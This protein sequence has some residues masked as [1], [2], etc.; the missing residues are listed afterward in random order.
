MRTRLFSVVH[1]SLPLWLA[2]Q[3]APL[4]AAELN[5]TVLDLQ[6]RALAGATVAASREPQE[7]DAQGQIVRRVQRSDALGRYRFE[8]LPAGRYQVSASFTGQ[9]A[10]SSAAQA[11]SDDAALGLAPLQLQPAAGT[12]RGT[13]RSSQGP[14]PAQVQMVALRVDG[15]NATFYGE[16]DA[17]AYALSLP[18]G[19]YLYRAVTAGHSSLHRQVILP[20]ALQNQDLVLWPNRGSDPTLAQELRRRDQADQSVRHRLGEA[21]RNGNPE[22]RQA[23]LTEMQSIDTDNRSWLQQLMARQGWPSAAQVGLSGVHAAW[24]LAQHAPEMLKSLLPAL[25]LAAARGELHQDSLALSIDRVLTTEGLPQRYGSQFRRDASG[26]LQMF[27][28]EDEAGLDA[29]RAAMGMEPIAS[30]RR[31][32]G[33]H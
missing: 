31:R 13:V 9:G 1:T 18:P 24:L 14:L 7:V 2:L 22:Q 17:G 25:E 30:Y 3:L 23:L 26:A 20:G 27:P 8:S 15:S 4:H 29:R 32:L 10:V 19:Q 16:L 11:V 12:L 6:G 21:E 5:G 33:A 28:V